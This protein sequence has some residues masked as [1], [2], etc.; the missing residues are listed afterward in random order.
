[1]DEYE[2][3]LAC[4]IYILCPNYLRFS[5]IGSLLPVLQ[6]LNI[7]YQNY[8]FTAFRTLEAALQLEEAQLCR[9]PG[10]DAPQ[11]VDRL[12]A[13]ASALL[14]VAHALDQQLVLVAFTFCVQTISAFQS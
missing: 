13:G 2:K 9:T 14:E 7:D 11:C 6:S 5:I 12:A 3:K 10:R 1:M 4:R 8:S